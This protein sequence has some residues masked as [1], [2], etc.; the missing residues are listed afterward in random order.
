MND[1]TDIKNGLNPVLKSGGC[2]TIRTETISYDE[3]DVLGKK[4]G[5]TIIYADW[6]PNPEYR[7]SKTGMFLSRNEKYPSGLI[8]VDDKGIPHPYKNI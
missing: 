6:H 8:L 2:V 1:T 3:Y 4:F 5:V 7:I